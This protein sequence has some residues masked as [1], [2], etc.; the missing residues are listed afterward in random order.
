M[1]RKIDVNKFIEKI[2]GISLD[3]LEELLAKVRQHAAKKREEEIKKYEAEI[4]RL[5]QPKV[6]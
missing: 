1:A 2:Q 3:Q 4:E 6:A 5:K